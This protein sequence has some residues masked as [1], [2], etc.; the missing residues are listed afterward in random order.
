[1]QE[2]QITVTLEE[3]NLLLEALGQLPF[4]RVYQLIAKIQQQAQTQFR[5]EPSNPK[6]GEKDER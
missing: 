3:A 2:I 5:D 1:M 4:V 6:S